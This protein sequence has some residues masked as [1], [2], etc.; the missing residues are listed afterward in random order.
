MRGKLGQYRMNLEV[1]DALLAAAYEWTKSG[2]Q[3][4]YILEH[5]G[6]TGYVGWRTCGNK[7]E[8]NV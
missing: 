8:L 5:G 3:E 6:R 4:E 1:V 7:G 2:S